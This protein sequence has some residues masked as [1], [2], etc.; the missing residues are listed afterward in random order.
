MSGRSR[1]RGVAPGEVLRLAREA[2]GVSQR[3]LAARAGTSGATV[4][5]YESGRK[6]PRLSTLE[7]LVEAAG[8]DLRVRVEPVMTRTDRRSLALHAAVAERLRR[9]PDRV[10]RR[11]RRNLATMRAASPSPSALR[12]LEEWEALLASG[13]DAVVAALR[14]PAEH[15]RDLRQVSPFAGVLDEDERRA[16]VAAVAELL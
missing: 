1:R 12:L 16:V 3:E 15:A 14:D 2:A 4:A 11:A 9:E 6:E 8:Q 7:R 5:A 10:L 13:V